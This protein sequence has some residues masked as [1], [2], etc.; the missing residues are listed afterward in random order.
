MDSQ[1]LKNIVEA[2]LLAAGS[3]VTIDQ[4]RALFGDEEQPDKQVVRAA[5]AELKDDYE[6]RGIEVREV[7]S[8]FR[9]Q[10]REAMSPWLAKLWEER[11]PRYSRALME[12]L[13]IIAYRQPVTRGD[14][15]EI[16]GVSVTTNI[17]RT[18]QERDWIKVVG[19]RDVP[20]KPA[21]FGTT[22]MFLD[23]FG[24]KKLDDL[25]PLAELAELEPM[26][27][28][29]E[30]ASGEGSSAAESGSADAAEGQ[31][32][33]STEAQESGEAEGSVAESEIP[34]E[35]QDDEPVAP[36]AQFSAEL[37][38]GEEDDVSEDELAAAMSAAAISIDEIRERAESAGA[39][40][41]GGEVSDADDEA[42][43]TDVTAE[44]AAAENGES[45]SNAIVVS[46]EADA[47][48]VSDESADDSAD[49]V[50]EAD[51]VDLPPGAVK[52]LVSLS[53][54]DAEVFAESDAESA[55]VASIEDARAAAESRTGDADD[56]GQADNA[57]DSQDGQ[58]SA[59][60]VPLKN[61]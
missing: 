14:V 23:Y 51:D 19:H 27:V 59:D 12:T 16:R 56:S 7:A 28:Q 32:P 21:M 39:D 8:G 55:N 29:L 50:D 43:D 47:V 37:E 3:P 10:V 26:G 58:D 31:A 6:G 5:V 13:A 52:P 15:E 60:I 1:Q 20:G 53:A 9:V 54:P 33:D 2:A 25:P 17:I 24:L 18:L 35:P 57:D 22:R 49:E 4:L 41:D 61:S 40:A 42:A 48:E 45:D 44:D 36:L 34:N 30:L 11:P 38:T 46:E